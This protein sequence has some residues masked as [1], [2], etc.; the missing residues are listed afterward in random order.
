MKSVISVIIP[1]FNSSLYIDE[2][3]KSLFAQSYSAWEA[4]CVNDGSV[5]DTLDK[6]RHY[7]KLDSR[8]IVVDQ[9]NLGVSVARRNGL[10]KSAGVY[11]TFL[12]S[13][14]TLVPTAL[15]DMLKSAEK[16]QSDIVVSGFNIVKEGKVVVR[17]KPLFSIL[18]QVNYL[19]LVMLGKSGWE[20]CGKLYRRDCF[21]ENLIFNNFKVAEDASLFFQIVSSINIISSCSEPVYNYIQN[22][23]SVSY[24]Q[25]EL[26]AKQVLEAFFFIRDYFDKNG[27]TNYLKD[28]I[29]GMALLFYSTSMRRYYLGKDHPYVK[30]I[31]VKYANTKSFL[32][33]PVIKVLFVLLMHYWG[34]KNHSFLLRLKKIFTYR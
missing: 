16:Y 34:S 13:D 25:S 4:L 7:S 27:M 1:C 32:C 26:C 29:G 6:L 10:E 24:N 2:C 28:E 14:D 21:H 11:V 18:S 5:D 8:I 31:W 22:A 9:K 20:L 23:S 12:D 33:I 15:Y 30:E 3:L 19:K 17:K